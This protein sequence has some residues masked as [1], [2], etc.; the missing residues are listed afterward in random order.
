MSGVINVWCDQCP[1]LH[2]VWSMSGVIN[3]WCD[4]CLCD[5]CRTITSGIIKTVQSFSQPNLFDPSSLFWCTI[6]IMRSPSWSF[7]VVARQLEEIFVELCLRL[8]NSQAGI[9]QINVSISRFTLGDAD[10]CIDLTFYKY[11]VSTTVK[12]FSYFY[13][14]YWKVMNK[15]LLNFDSDLIISL[16]AGAKVSKDYKKNISSKYLS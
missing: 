12:G 14:H 6:K 13:I 2:T 16:L 10:I 8:N 15:I 3:V 4:Q 5:Q 1:I 9:G 11:L 7:I